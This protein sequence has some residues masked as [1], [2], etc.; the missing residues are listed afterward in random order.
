[1]YFSDNPADRYYERMMVGIPNF[2]PRGH[3]VVIV[4]SR[5]TEPLVI[6]RIQDGTATHREILIE[7]TKAIN[8]RRF[9]HHLNQYLKESEMNAMQI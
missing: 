7:T 2:K 5:P 9:R 4:G 8:H 3:G 1:M 6:L